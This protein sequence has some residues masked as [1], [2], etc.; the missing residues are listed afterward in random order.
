MRGPTRLNAS[1]DHTYVDNALFPTYNPD[2]V[3]IG[4]PI[5]R[6]DHRTVFVSGDNANKSRSV[7]R[8]VV[9]DFIESHIVAFEK[10]FL[11]GDLHVFYSE[12]DI[13]KKCDIFYRIMSDAMT[14][15][16]TRVVLL[17]DRDV[18]WMTPFLK[19]LI[20]Q[21]WQAYTEARTGPTTMF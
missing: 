12:T 16:P 10:H 14:E 3:E 19:N 13:D 4:P 5:G 20:D 21:R 11:T 17:T 18:P 8:H 15:I 2:C 6:S 9:H 7:R 1:L